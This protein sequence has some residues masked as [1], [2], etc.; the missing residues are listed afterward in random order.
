M[1][2]QKVGDLSGPESKHEIGRR[3]GTPKRP[4][5]LVPV[6]V[7]VAVLLIGLLL[8]NFTR[9]GPNYQE[10]EFTPDAVEQSG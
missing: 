9:S 8:F 5:Y 2:R 1:A 6:I 4:S 3:D 10:E 7:V